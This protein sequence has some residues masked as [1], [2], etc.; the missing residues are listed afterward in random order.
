MGDKLRIAKALQTIQGKLANNSLNL[1]D[2]N[3]RIK[4]SKRLKEF[5]N[6]LTYSEK[7][8]QLY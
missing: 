5:D 2:I 1:T 7:Q 3:E 6:D 8:R 4:N